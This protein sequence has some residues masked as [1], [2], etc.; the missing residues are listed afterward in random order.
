MKLLSPAQCVLQIQIH[1]FFLVFV[2]VMVRFGY[3]RRFDFTIMRYCCFAKTHSRSRLFLTSS[4]IVFSFDTLGRVI[5]LWGYDKIPLTDPGWVSHWKCEIGRIWYV[6]YCL[7][8][9]HAP[10][11]QCKIRLY[12]LHLSPMGANFAI[13]FWSRRIDRCA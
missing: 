8:S 4:S 12:P 13:Q 1:D 3:F 10:S 9:T 5:I 2:S 7:T 11:R 6:M